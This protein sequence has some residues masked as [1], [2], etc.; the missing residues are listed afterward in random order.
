M[1]SSPWT[2]LVL[3]LVVLAAVGCGGDMATLE[4]KVTVGGEPPPKGD[5]HGHVGLKLVEGGP[6]ANSNL[7]KDGSFRISTGGTKG[8]KPGT[9]QVVLTGMLGVPRP[10]APPGRDGTVRWIPRK[11]ANFETSGLTLE[12]KPGRNTKT[13]DIPKE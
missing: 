8:L 10:G 2:Y 1:T 12:V 4:G 5:F 3:G 7:D 13:I 9:Y 11:Y 6:V